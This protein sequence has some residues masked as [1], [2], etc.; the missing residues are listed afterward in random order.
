ML[1]YLL[2]SVD[3]NM[4]SSLFGSSRFMN[5]GFAFDLLR[6][7]RF[8]A[9][10]SSSCPWGAVGLLVVLVAIT[11]WWCGFAVA[12]CVLSQHCRRVVTVVLRALISS[13]QAPGV[14]PDLR[15]RLAEYHRSG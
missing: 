10:A 2:H 13:A 8:W 14:P 6:E 7:L 11:C 15:G 5:L 9:P 12:A 3:V 1:S 4:A